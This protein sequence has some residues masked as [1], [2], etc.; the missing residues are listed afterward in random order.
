ME[1][2]ASQHRQT[3][4]SLE[5]EFLREPYKYE[6]HQA[7][8]ILEAL[9]AETLRLGEGSDPLREALHISSQLSMA[10]PPSDIFAIKCTD[11]PWEMSINF[12][13]IGG[14]QGPLPLA[15]TEIMMGRL[16]KNDASMRRFLDIFNHRLI[17]LHRRIGKKYLPGLGHVSPKENILSTCI[18]S[19]LG[20][21]FT[22]ALE[23][24]ENG[25]PFNLFKYAGIFW[26]RPRSTSGLQVIL[27]DYF[28]EPIKV[29]PFT[30][31]WMY[32]E[33]DQV[34]RIGLSGQYQKLGQGTTLG[35]RV[36]NQIAGFTIEIG[37]VGL[38]S[39]LKFLKTG[40]KFRQLVELTKLYVDLDC[41]I[42]LS[43]ILKKEEVPKTY[44]NGQAALGWLSGLYHH[45]KMVE[46]DVQI[47][48]DV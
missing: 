48:F 24:L 16:A 18:L 1:D 7:V 40:K 29:L 42:T 12:F 11:E 30:G 17:S 45:D 31:R 20:L 14:V 25:S 28:T 39:F 34:T 15:Y 2:L 27:Q 23:V 5:E 44:L 33:E 10:P 41:H 13:G 6:F 47:K 21:N 46:K 32:I 26:Q 35:T 43:L 9:K 8:T 38:V 22:K 36:W 19:F 3:I 4:S 37:P